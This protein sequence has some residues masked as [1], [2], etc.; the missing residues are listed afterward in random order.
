M[1][2]L[3]PR[4]YFEND[5]LK[6]MLSKNFRE[7]GFQNINRFIPIKLTDKKKLHNVTN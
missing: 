6:K 3:L 5:H 1:H 4:F 7:N 2:R